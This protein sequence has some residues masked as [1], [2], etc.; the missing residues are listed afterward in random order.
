M[1]LLTAISRSGSLPIESS[2]LHVIVAVSH[3]FENE[4]VDTVIV[5]NINPIEKMRRSMM[6]IASVIHNVP[7]ADLT[8]DGCNGGEEKKEI[9]YE[10]SG[11]SPWVDQAPELAQDQT[12]CCPEESDTE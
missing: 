2:E 7:E 1:D 3:C 5:D 10:G 11:G 8:T 4:I 12:S 9:E 6:I